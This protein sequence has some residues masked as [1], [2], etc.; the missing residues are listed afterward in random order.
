MNSGTDNKTQHEHLT[1]RGVAHPEGALRILMIDSETTWRGGQ[2]QLALLV[3]GLREYGVDLRVAAPPEAAIFENED[4]RGIAR[5]PL[6]MRNGMDLVAAARLAHH[7]QR[8][9]YDVLHCHSSHAHSTAFLATRP[10]KLLRNDTPSG[11]LP[12]I[13]VSRRVAFP[14]ARRGPSALKYRHADLYLAISSAVRD[15]LTACGVDENQI[16]LV[17]SGVDV[18]ALRTRRSRDRVRG[19]LGID[20]HSRVIGTIAALTANKSVGDLV[21]AARFVADQVSDLRVIIVGEGP[22]HAEIEMLVAALGLQERVMLTGF[23]DDAHDVLAALDCFVLPSRVEGLGTSIMD[24]HVLGVPV[25]A[26]RTGGIPDLV[27]DGEN[28]LL[29]PPGDPQ[30]LGNAIV[31]MLCDGG[32]RERCVNNARARA[33]RYDY[34]NMVQGTMD[35]YQAVTG[36]P[37]TLDAFGLQ[38]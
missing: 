18:D 38:P 30:V 11:T 10:R 34:R 7:L 14:I 15:A 1:P 33:R 17:P 31:R 19:E 2:N 21:Q 8:E 22:A 9:R 5:V 3:R 37:R 32:L 12:R 23:R 27:Q 6:T 35:A 29:V 24:A 13:V 4:L 16:T 25:V 26:T 36:R 20:R 28:G